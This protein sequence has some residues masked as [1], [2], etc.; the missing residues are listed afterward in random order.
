M[1]RADDE[2]NF[3]VA[4]R[5]G[6]AFDRQS[7][8]IV[9]HDWR[10]FHVLFHV[11]NFHDHNVHVDFFQHDVHFHV[12]VDHDYNR[13][14]R[15]Y[16]GL[17][18]LE[19]R[20]RELRHLRTGRNHLHERFLYGQLRERGL[21]PDRREH[22][23]GKRSRVDHL[24]PLVRRGRHAGDIQPDPDRRRRHGERKMEDTGHGQRLLRRRNGSDRRRAL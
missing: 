17:D 19:L 1:Y 23:G 3:R 9:I 2:D 5:E 12:I 13:P 21:F 16:F 8:K 18:N 6:D 20:R 15:T 4:L 14:L 22:K 7:D 10:E 24:H 11:H